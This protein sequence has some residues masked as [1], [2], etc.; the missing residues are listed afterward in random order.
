MTLLQCAGGLIVSAKIELEVA[1][2][3]FFISIIFLGII[4]IIGSLFFILMDRVNGKDFFQ[5]FDRKKDEMFNLIQ[6]SE[7]MIQ[8][9]NR[10]SDYVVTVISEK[11]QEIINKSMIPTAQ[12]LGPGMN[13]TVYT[14][15]QAVSIPQREQKHDSEPEKINAGLKEKQQL[16]AQL[17]NNIPE[18][19]AEDFKNIKPKIS[20]K[21]RRGEVVKMIEQG[22]SNDEIAGKM[23]IGKG[24]IELIRGLSK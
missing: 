8:E 16:N 7:E 21:D 23:K 4:L 6:E 11:N 1:M 9:L 18:K 13:N 14:L 10:M 20:L 3:A 12:E 2:E 24:E 15:Q 5:E 22:L 17:P 19:I